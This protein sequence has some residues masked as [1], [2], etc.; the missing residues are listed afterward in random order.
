M[1]Y[2][3]GF[4]LASI[5]FL[6][7]TMACVTNTDVEQIDVGDQVFI[8]NEKTK[9]IYNSSLS[10][11][12]VIEENSLDSLI[13]NS[14]NISPE[15]IVW[16]VDSSSS[17]RF[18]IGQHI[19]IENKD[20]LRSSRVLYENE[21]RLVNEFIF[22]T[23]TDS[24][25]YTYLKEDYFTKR[26]AKVLP[27]KISFKNKQYRAYEFTLKDDFSEEVITILDGMGV[28]KYVRE[29][30]NSEGR[31]FRFESKINQLSIQY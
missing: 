4:I 22:P 16:E 3:V 23:E 10:L 19:H 15:L 5:V 7:L 1:K 25:I 31:K 29:G 26:K 21:Y 24:I 6:V 9:W 8:V 17:T 13:I 14:I 11:D 12:G 30:V 28:Y 27:T 20:T 18:G 2:K